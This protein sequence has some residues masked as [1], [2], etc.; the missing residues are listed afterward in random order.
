MGGKNKS[1]GAPLVLEA[2]ALLGSPS[3]ATFY[4][5]KSGDVRK[6]SHDTL[7][8]ISLILGI[9]KALSILHSDPVIANEWIGRPNAVLGGDSARVRMCAGEI[10]DLLRVREYL[11]G[12]RGGWA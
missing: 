9:Y 5:W 8:R 11:D 12:V 10:V 2:Q 7:T 6:L 1:D 3:R 4:K